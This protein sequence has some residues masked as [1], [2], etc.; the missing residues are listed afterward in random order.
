MTAATT[1]STVI[2]EVSK[3]IDS[4]EA[5]YKKYRAT[6]ERKTREN[7]AAREAMKNYTKMLKKLEN[8]RNHFDDRVNEAAN[9]KIGIL[10]SHALDFIKASDLW[11]QFMAFSSKIS[12]SISRK[13][14]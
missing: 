3:R 2:K 10:N 4:I 5:K 11:E 1:C 6:F 12:Q 8:D 7:K 13:L 14:K 9:K